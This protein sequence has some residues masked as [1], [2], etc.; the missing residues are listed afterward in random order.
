MRLRLPALILVTGLATLGIGGLARWPYQPPGRTAALLRL[1]WHLRGER[2]ERCRT[3]TQ[4]E[5]DALPAHMR[6]P[7]VCETRPLAYQLVVQLDEERPDTSLILPGGV[8]GDRPLFVLQDRIMTP[9]AHRL[10]ISFTRLKGEHRERG[11]EHERDA[12]RERSDQRGPAQLALDITV[13][14]IA[15]TIE[16]ITLDDESHRFVHRTRP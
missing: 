7:E 10:R 12:D 14:A 3:R 16:L 8:K 11:V 9:G 1:S 13:N 15:G 4:A 5:L 6:T 2:L